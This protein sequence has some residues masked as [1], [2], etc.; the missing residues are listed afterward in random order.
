MNYIAA[1]AHWR[2]SARSVRFFVWDAK[3]AF[4]FVLFL[5]YMS[6]WTFGLAFGAMIFFS[7][8]NRYGFSIEVFGRWLRTSLAGK[9][10]VAIPWWAN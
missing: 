8:L 5:L 2:D 7:V 10:K 3:A 6:W 4:P 1:D 9:R